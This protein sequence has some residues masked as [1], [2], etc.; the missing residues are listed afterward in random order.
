MKE[1]LKMFDPQ[2]Y[3]TSPKSTSSPASASGPELFGKLDG[4]TTDP[5]GQVHVPVNHSA[6]LAKVL[7]LMTSGTYGRTSS[8]SSSS[9]ALQQSLESRLRAKTQSL[10]S[11]LYKLTWKP[12]ATP[13]GVS[14]SRLRGSALRTSATDCTGWPTPMAMD[15]WMASTERKGEGQR[16]LP[17][18]AAIAGWSTPAKANG[19][20]GQTMGHCSPTGRRADGTKTQVTLNGIAALAGWVTPSARDWK[21]TPGMSAQRDGK[22]R[23]DQLPRQAYLAGWP[24]PLVGSTT[25]AAHGQISGQ[26]R[27]AMEPCKPN[28]DSPARLT[29]S[30]E[31]LTGSSAEMESG[32]QLNP[33]HSRWLMGLPIEWDDCA[34]T[35]TPSTLK[36][37][38]SS[39]SV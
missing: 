3:V 12:W 10:G 34:P 23:V 22:D 6:R 5:C 27:A 9:A 35:E 30:G 14:R 13:S 20:G 24:T 7:D 25:P 38:A 28:T 1:A 17:N 2:I 15:S 32:G 11:T 16:Q 36:R 33:A 39:S 18:I 37:R 4:L 19:D 29:A 31:M 21:D 26:W 8:I